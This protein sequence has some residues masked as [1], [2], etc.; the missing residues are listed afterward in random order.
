MRKI[1]LL[2]AVILPH[3]LKL[4]IYRRVMGWEIGKQVKIGFS[5]IECDEVFMGDNIRIR[6]FNIIRGLKRLQV[7]SNSYVANLNEFFGNNS[8]DEK[9][10]N[11]L[12]VNCGKP[13]HN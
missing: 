6:H 7:G 1:L 2:L 13:C 11:T 9:W 3:L 12:S 4:F 10:K 8:S 5:Y